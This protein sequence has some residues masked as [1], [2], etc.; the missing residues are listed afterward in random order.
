MI[1]ER[2][3]KRQG[4]RAENRDTRRLVEGEAADLSHPRHEQA[5]IETA[6]HVALALVFAGAEVETIEDAG[7]SVDAA[8]PAAFLAGRA[9]ERGGVARRVIPEPLGLPKPT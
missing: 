3:H 7:V 2:R 4:G 5:R 1:D 8:A 9:S 6:D